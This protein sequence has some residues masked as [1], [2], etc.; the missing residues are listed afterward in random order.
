MASS[1][2]HKVAVS[3]DVT[4]NFRV[5]ERDGRYYVVELHVI[6]VELTPP[7]LRRLPLARIEALAN[8]GALERAMGRWPSERPEP[9]LKDLRAPT[10]DF[11][12]ASGDDLKQILRDGAAGADDITV[13]RQRAKLTR[14]DGRDPAAFYEQVAVA[15]RDV[16]SRATTNPP[17]VTDALADE[18]GVPPGTARRWIMEARRRGFLPPAKRRG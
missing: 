5:A 1:S 7:L 8:A 13:D 10:A 4:A 15:Y 14:P 18:A 3:P 11:R 9:T 6:G 12:L 17:G 2:W 16:L